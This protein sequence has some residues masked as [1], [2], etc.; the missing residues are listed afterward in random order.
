[1]G[2]GGGL[3]QVS[4]GLTRQGCGEGVAGEGVAGEAVGPPT[5]GMQHI[6]GACRPTYAQKGHIITQLFFLI[7]RA[8]VVSLD[9]EMEMRR[10]DSGP[11]TLSVA[12][13][14]TLND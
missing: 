1:M 4:K 12:H 8:A 10:A 2:V 7:G 5:S 3:Q 14:K 9:G 6:A 11:T 13:K